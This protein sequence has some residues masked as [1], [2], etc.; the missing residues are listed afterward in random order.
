VT[1]DVV[2]PLPLDQAYTYRVPE[3]HAASVQVGARVLVP[4][5]NR[6][7]TGVVVG[8]GPSP[9]TLDFEVKAVLDVLDDVPVCTPA[10][11]DLT[12]WIADYYV[13]SWGEAL[14]AVL[15]AGTT[16]KSEHRLARTDAAP[17]RWAEHDVGRRVLDDLAGRGETTLAA[18]RRRVGP[19][20]PLALIRRMETDGVLAVETTLSDER[21]QPKTAVHLRFAPAFQ[22]RSAADDLVEQLRGEKQRAVIKALAGF[23]ARGTPEPRQAEVVERTDAPY[24]TIRSLV[25]KGMIERVEKEVLRSPLDDLPAPEPPPDHTLLP[26]QQD[27]LSA[28]TDAVDAHRYDTFLL[29]GITG[30]GKTEVYIRAL[31]AVRAEG[32]TGIILVPEIA[33][34]PQTVQRFRAHFGDEIAVLH[35]Q[36]SMGE[37]YDAW[38]RLRTGDATI[39][40]GPRSAVLAPLEDL[41]LIVVDEEHETSYKQFDPAP[42]YHARDVAVLRAHRTDAVCVLGSATPSLESTMNARWG[43]YERLL[44]PDRVPDASGQ[45]AALP[46]VRILDLTVQRKKHQLDGVLADPLRTAIRER[47]ERDEQVIL[48]QNR[49][50]YAPVL[51][52]EDCGWAP[53]CTSC[54]VSL[55]LHRAA[56]RRQLRCHYCGHSRQLSGPRQCPQCGSDDLSQ[57]GVG[58]QRVEAELREVVPDATVLRMDRDTTSQKHGHHAILRRFRN[59]ADVLLGTQ[60]IAKGLDFGRVTLVGVVDADVGL[61]FPD[62]RA[63]ERTFQLLTQVAGRAGRADLRGEVILQTRNPDHPALR[64]ATQHDY[65]GFVEEELPTRRQFGYPPFGHVAT[66]EFRGADADRV[67][68]LAVNWTE[69]LSSHAGPVEV[70][71]PE[72][73]FIQR[74]KKQHRYRTLLKS[75][76]GSVQPLQAAL[77]RTKEARSSPPNGYHVAVDVDT[78]DVL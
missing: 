57:I 37:R 59:G 22:S 49:R 44:L 71:G 16:V 11:L 62:F 36:M 68:R 47:A 2:L 7:L 61:L 26:A 74:V 39:A 13:C 42:R 52:C 28:I 23:R 21:V 20:V 18:V 55:T 45:T 10:L 14:K 25:D 41:G 78:Q 33:L 30:S 35:S 53:E 51:E 15:P 73:A 67:E 38:R 12:N 64:Y 29:H 4:F 70:M 43:K 72:P 27:A 8:E 63:E 17:G 58:T 56:G 31:K 75:R 5:R 9:R 50:G 34:T 54:S 3:A 48:L 66:V 46:E 32:R 76:G 69:T 1:I 60:M 40:I 77:R 19:A 6:R 24:S 65:E